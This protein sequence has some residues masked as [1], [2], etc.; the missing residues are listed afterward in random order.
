MILN[1]KYVSLVFNLKLSW[2][3][4]LGSLERSCN[5][6]VN[7]EKSTSSHQQLRKKELDTI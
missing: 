4:L 7:L 1:F 2:E 5:S 3:I 6:S